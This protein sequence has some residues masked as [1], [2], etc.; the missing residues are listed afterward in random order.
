M[1]ENEKEKF[2]LTQREQLLLR[3]IRRLGWG[4]L[5]IRVENGQPV[6]I[7]EAIRTFKLEENITR[8]L[9]LLED[10]PPPRRPVTYRMEEKA[11]RT[12]YK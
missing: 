4:D 6:V 2:P 9:P 5:K 11:R 3:F 12:A 1:P 8:D 10:E 7:Y